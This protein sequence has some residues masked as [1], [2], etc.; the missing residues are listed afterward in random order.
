[1]NVNDMDVLLIHHTNPFHTNYIK[2]FSKYGAHVM[3]VVLILPAF[4]RHVPTYCATFD[5]IFLRRP[6][7]T[8]KRSIPCPHWYCSSKLPYGHKHPS[9][10][11][12]IAEVDGAAA[13]EEDGVSDI[14][15]VEHVLYGHE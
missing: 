7:E 6:C 12:V 4:L 5:S 14:A 8:T 3:F 13:W 11:A 1:M 10:H 15:E 9:E 2:P